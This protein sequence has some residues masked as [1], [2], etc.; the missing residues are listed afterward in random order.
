VLPGTAELVD[1]VRAPHV[2]RSVALFVRTPAA[3]TGTWPSLG[4]RV[5]D[6]TTRPFD[7]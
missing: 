6:E 7:E 5:I 1:I 4:F 3:S 2:Q